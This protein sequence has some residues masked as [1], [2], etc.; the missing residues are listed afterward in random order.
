MRTGVNGLNFSYKHMPA[1]GLA[2]RQ[3]LDIMR[4]TADDL[5]LVTKYGITN[6]DDLNSAKAL[7]AGRQ[8]FGTG[9]AFTIGQAYVDG[10][11]TG[12]GPF[13]PRMKQVWIDSGWKPRHVRING[14]WIDYSPFEPF[15]TLMS[16]IANIGDNA[17]GMGPEWAEK[18]LAQTAFAVGVGAVSKTYTQGFQDLVS[19]FSS[20]G[21][22]VERVFGSMAN[23]FAPFS[24]LR[25]DVSK[26]LTPYMREINGS[27][28]ETIR[29]RNTGLELIA[30]K[31]LPL[32]YDLL[33]GSPLRDWNFWQRTFNAVSGVNISIEDDSPG[34]TL[35][36]DS[37]YNYAIKGFRYNNV[38]MT[39]HPE[40]RSMFQRAIGNSKIVL[41]NKT[42]KNPL[43]ALD[44]IA[45]RPEVQ[46]S[47]RI[48][49]ANRGTD[50]AR[51]DPK[52]AYMHNKLINEIFGQAQRRAW[53]SIQDDP[54]VQALI[55]KKRKDEVDLFRTQ[56]S[57]IPQRDVAPI[58]N[59]YK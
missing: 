12:D 13:D 27:I 33:D 56:Q 48:M 29:N 59:L 34:R 31:P 19:L 1:L 54:Q 2:H 17:Y 10:N 21:Q 5:S 39:D 38:D 20:G 41:G 18:N 3:S 26:V 51:F 44:A 30:D 57:T 15:A 8:A 24:G 25:N 7:L 50:M 52:Q 28:E 55:E 43:E 45:L 32:K 6:A 58:L 23:S 47:L 46:E 37:N 22:R 49:E 9:I 40:V 16:T 35:L 4:A 14:V 53:A 36:F 11:L 42:Y